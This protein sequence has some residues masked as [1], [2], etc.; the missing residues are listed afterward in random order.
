M[1]RRAT[2]PILPWRA[3]NRVWPWNEYVSVAR[4]PVTSTV[5]TSHSS[6]RFCFFVFLKND[7]QRL[8]GPKWNFTW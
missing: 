2:K 1:A 8:A 4:R 3:P 7:D 6:Q 5:I